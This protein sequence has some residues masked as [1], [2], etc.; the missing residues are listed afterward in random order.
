MFV[1]QVNVSPTDVGVYVAYMGF[2]EKLCP[3]LHVMKLGVLHMDG[4][5][6]CSHT[7]D[8]SLHHVLAASLT[9]SN[10]M[11]ASALHVY[12]AYIVGCTS[13]VRMGEECEALQAL[14]D[15]YRQ[16]SFLSR[17]EDIVLRE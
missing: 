14:A 8:R 12:I 2:D 9:G 4:L 5:R 13:M 16:S 1:P 3:M 10:S 7:L 17:Q 6:C 11:V 15:K